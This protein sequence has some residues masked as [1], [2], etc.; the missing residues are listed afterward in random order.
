MFKYNGTAAFLFEFE[1]ITLKPCWFKRS[2]THV[3]PLILQMVFETY[4]LKSTRS[5]GKIKFCRQ[6]SSL[7]QSEC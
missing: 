7:T 3:A 5:Q 2:F 6:R 1:N 4:S